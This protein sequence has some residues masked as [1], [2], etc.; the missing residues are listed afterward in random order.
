MGR[1][2][3][4]VD[5]KTE[6]REVDHHVV[7]SPEDKNVINS[8]A[9]IAVKYE[10]STDYSEMV[11]GEML[12]FDTP[13]DTT[14]EDPTCEIV[15]DEGV[16][17]FVTSS[18]GH[19]GE[20]IKES[21][22]SLIERD[23]LDNCH[24][25]MCHIN[26]IDDIHFKAMGELSKLNPCF[27]ESAQTGSIDQNQFSGN[28]TPLV[29]TEHNTSAE[30]SLDIG[31]E[32]KVSVPVADKQELMNL[33]V[34]TNRSEEKDKQIHCESNSEASKE[35]ESEKNLESPIQNQIESLDRSDISNITENTSS[36]DHEVQADNTSG[37]SKITESQTERLTKHQEEHNSENSSENI[38]RQRRRHRCHPYFPS[39]AGPSYPLSQGLTCNLSGVHSV[40]NQ[41]TATN[42]LLAKQINCQVPMQQNVSPEFRF[43]RPSIC[44]QTTESF[45]SS[46]LPR[47]GG[48]GHFYQ[49]QAL[50][51]AMIPKTQVAGIGERNQT[52]FKSVKNT[53]NYVNPSFRELSSS[54]FDSCKSSSVANVNLYNTQTRPCLNRNNFQTQYGASAS[55]ERIPGTGLSQFQCLIDNQDH[56]KFSHT[57]AQSSVL[58][59]Q[60]SLHD[61]DTELLDTV[62]PSPRPGYDSNTFSNN[63]NA[64]VYSGKTQQGAN[65]LCVTNHAA[66]KSGSAHPYAGNIFSHPGNLYS[67]QNAI[68]S[69]V[70]SNIPNVHSYPRN[71]SHD[72]RNMS[73]VPNNPLCSY[74]NNQQFFPPSQSSN[75]PMRNHRSA[76]L[77]VRNTYPTN[78]SNIYTSSSS[79]TQ[80]S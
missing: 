55:Q 67:Q 57:T 2:T 26:Q 9:D 61:F 21:D 75:Y 44:N 72:L 38:K 52:G 58:E 27:D 65:N 62:D 19:N 7:I 68:S 3:E 49:F 15:I 80:N 34:K 39:S 37:L 29:T 78:I 48:T 12:D 41:E 35:D 69:N 11:F 40:P 76:N 47:S 4:N 70:C 14:S 31:K 25:N 66:G 79:N 50:K 30:I 71:V 8:K 54:A 18:C 32:G 59:F 53:Q 22:R 74:S 16:A 10:K 17:G 77:G 24:S 73:V 60:Q 23:G 46:Q 13:E 6:A 36:R 43:L 63:P 64:A 51:Q 56:R 20:V 33:E 28:V 5:I 45:F 1:D 42:Y